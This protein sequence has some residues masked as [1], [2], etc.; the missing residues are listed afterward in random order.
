M[1]KPD[2]TGNPPWLFGFLAAPA[3]IYYWGVSAL[4]IPYLLRKHGVPV[5]RIAGVVAIAS[6]PN[7]WFFLWSPVVDL[8]LRRRTWI[9]LSAALA[10]LCGLVA[11]LESAGPLIVLTSFLFAGNVSRALADSAIGAVMTTVRPEVRGRAA[12]WFQAGNIGAG[13]LGGGATIWLAASAGL[14]L[15]AAFS[16]SII[17][18]P[19]LMALRVVETPHPRLAAGPLFSALFRDV[20]DVLSSWRTF[21]GLVFFASPVGVGALGNLISSVGPDYRAS[22]AE[23]A[24]VTGLA[25]GLLTAL[26]AVL[27]GPVCDRLHRM[28]A[29]AVAGILSGLCGA[30]LGLGPLTPFTCGAGYAAYAL[31]TGF[32]Y[33]AYSSLIL[34]VLGRRQRGAATGYSLLSASGN[35]PVSYMTWM[36][37]VGY[38][39]A[40]VRGLM[41]V[42][43][44]TN[45]V[46]GL[47]LLLVALYFA[48]RWKPAQ[49][50]IPVEI[51]A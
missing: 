28:T 43:A 45:G 33:T 47:I 10:S 27:G 20:W 14:P 6:I 5:N 21:L 35:L 19:A 26:G 44:A 46:G 17:F 12:G 30:W 37:G 41:G 18:V 1:S 36:D 23:V 13:A 11:I 16:A 39:H 42:D 24:W 31:T 50:G 32:A 38:R 40:G 4:L 48:K 49:A 15:L 34:E 22:G 9:L 8:G 25:G 29:Y 3:G 2:P 7:I 51:R